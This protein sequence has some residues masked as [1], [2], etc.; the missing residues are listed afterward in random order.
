MSV[1][2]DGFFTHG[3]PV[4]PSLIQVW[5]QLLYV[6]VLSSGIG[7][8]AQAIG[9]RYAPPTVAAIVMSLESVFACLGGVLLL[10]ERMTSREILGCALVF[11]AVLVAQIVPKAA[12][13]TEAAT[14][15]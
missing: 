6:G 13:V 5:P 14:P 9:Q 3:E 10:G 11:I 12:P 7:F 8:T 2:L 1:F 4:W 15:V